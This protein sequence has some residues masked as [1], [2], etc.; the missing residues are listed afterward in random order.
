MPNGDILPVAEKDEQAFLLDAESN[1]I[2]VELITEEPEK[3][4]TETV[5]SQSN[6]KEENTE[7]SEPEYYEYESEEFDEKGVKKGSYGKTY[8]PSP[9]GE[10][11]ESG[12]FVHEWLDTKG[13]YYK[14]D[15]GTV[16]HENL[17]GQVTA[18][19]DEDEYMQHRESL[20]LPQTWAGIGSVKDK[21]IGKLDVAK[22][23]SKKKVDQK[24]RFELEEKYR[25]ITGEIGDISSMSI[26]ELKE[27]TDKRIVPGAYGPYFVDENNVA[28]KN[29]D[30]SI[31]DLDKLNEQT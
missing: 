2:T 10:V 8:M 7:S 23:E 12:D 19:G 28:I 17:D 9:S 15:S 30:L 26:K 22:T 13:Q 16:Y 27:H 1:G 14:D 3:P 5:P 31:D 20:G 11:D 18:F 21:D 24:E 4:V 6:Q 29:E 25:Q